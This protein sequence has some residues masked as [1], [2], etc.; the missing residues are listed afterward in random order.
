MVVLILI[1][2]QES[3]RLIVQL[4]ETAGPRLPG[5]RETADSRVQMQ[6]DQQKQTQRLKVPPSPSDD[7]ES[8]TAILRLDS[9]FSEFACEVRLHHL[10]QSLP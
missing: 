10:D 5:K 8:T 7:N 3:H 1:P 2:D 9:A 6:D 4:G